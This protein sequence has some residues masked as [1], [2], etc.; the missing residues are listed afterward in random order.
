MRKVERLKPYPVPR[1]LVEGQRSE[2]YTLHFTLYTLHFTL[3]PIPRSPFP[4]PR[5]FSK[6]PLALA[7][8]FLIYYTS[9]RPTAGSSLKTGSLEIKE[10]CNSYTRR[11][12]N[13]FLAKRIRAHDGC[14]GIGRRRRTRKTATSSGEP[15]TGFDPEVSEWDNPAPLA[16]CRRRGEYM[17]PRS[18]TW[19]SETSQ[20]PE[21]QKS[22][23][24]C[25]S[26]GE[27]RR[28]SPNR[29]AC[30]PGLRDRDM[31]RE[32]TGEATG[33]SRHSG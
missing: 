14:L 10:N 5:F 17:A 2:F 31:A 26:S 24:D 1:S 25:V 22:T 11:A 9:V 4:V 12:R 18:H 16:G 32:R 7:W 23:R 8:P 15:S 13:R 6:Y 27:R 20:Y 19:G 3:F 28:R 29:E 30:F 33:K 21:E